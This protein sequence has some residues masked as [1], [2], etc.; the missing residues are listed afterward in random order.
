MKLTIL[1]A[2]L[3]A[4]A[5]PLCADEGAWAN[6]PD[7]EHVIRLPAGWAEAPAQR[8]LT[9]AGMTHLFS[10]TP[11]SRA[12]ILDIAAETDQGAGPVSAA[13]QFAKIRKLAG[14]PE[15]KRAGLAD[16]SMFEYFRGRKTEDDGPGYRVLG[17][18]NKHLQRYYVTVYSPKGVSA[19]KEW[20]KALQALGSLA[21]N[22]P[23]VDG[24]KSDFDKKVSDGG[25]VKSS[26]PRGADLRGAAVLRADGDIVHFEDIVVFACKN[27]ANNRYL[28][29]TDRTDHCWIVSPEDYKAIAGKLGGKYWGENTVIFQDCPA[30]MEQE[31]ACVPKRLRKF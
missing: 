19:Q 24:W 28:F 20:G 4:C 23:S 13:G 3:L 30:S 11:R 18:L 8:G 15:L 7:L 5:L 12:F 9:P 10:L 25:T 26:G 2:A 31:Q 27:F 29:N 14:S 6:S 16:N 17:I 22:D 21:P 1:C